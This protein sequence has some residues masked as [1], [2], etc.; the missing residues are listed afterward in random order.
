MFYGVLVFIFVIV[1]ILLMAI[2]L[3]Q[4]SQTGGM[5]TAMGGQAMNAAFGGQ[6]ADKLLV[7]IT[8]F[9]AFTFMILA[10]LIGYIG[11]PASQVISPE[12]PTLGRNKLSNSDS[13][14][15]IPLDVP[16]NA[17]SEE[18]KQNLKDQ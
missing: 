17:N 10:L 9:L 18:E 14:L 13:A 5:G 4:S 12:N 15:E 6:G 7:R 16:K 3:L 2:I 1:S 8:S 11:N